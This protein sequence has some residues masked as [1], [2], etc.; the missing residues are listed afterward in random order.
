MIVWLEPDSDK[1]A[2]ISKIKKLQTEAMYRNKILRLSWGKS[3]RHI[4][5]CGNVL[6][7]TSGFCWP[8][9]GTHVT[10][11]SYSWQKRQNSNYELFY[12][13]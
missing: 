1:F 10:K 9:L 7:G 11:E 3:L 6:M 2:A 12:K 5:R 4:V 8:I 13:E